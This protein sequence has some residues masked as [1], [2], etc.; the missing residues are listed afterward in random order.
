MKLT[1]K[2]SRI[3][4]YEVK[5]Y[6]EILECILGPSAVTIDTIANFLKNTTIEDGGYDY[7]YEL[8]RGNNVYLECEGLFNDGYTFPIEALE[9]QESMAKYF[10][11]NYLMRSKYYKNNLILDLDD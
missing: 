4:K 10:F 11:Y 1:I 6:I 2:N 9:S 7:A 8:K 3:V 5:S